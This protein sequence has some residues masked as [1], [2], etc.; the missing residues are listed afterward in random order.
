MA[1]EILQGGL[2]GYGTSIDWWSMGVLC[3]E[4][5]T[6]RSPFINE[7]DRESDISE[8]IL[9]TDPPMFYISCQDARDFI[10]R[11]LNKDPAQRLGKFCKKMIIF[12]C[13][14]NYLIF[15]SFLN[16]LWPIRND[17]NKGT[18][19][20]SRHRLVEIGEEGNSST[21]QTTSPR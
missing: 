6:G 11:L 1:P 8:Q 17:R 9:N 12:F 20:F 18:S 15:T 19:I 21:I 16:R 4:L 2:D 10:A 5:L 14:K 7:G 3:F 13:G